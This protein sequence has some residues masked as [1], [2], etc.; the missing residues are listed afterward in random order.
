MAN[1]Q[2]YYKTT[3]IDSVTTQGGPQFDPAHPVNTSP[4]NTGLNALPP[5]RGAF[6]WYPYAPSPE[7][8]IVG[9]GGRTAEAGPVFY[10]DDFKNAARPFPPYYDGKLFIYEFMRHWIMAVTMDK[11]GDLASIEQFMPNAKFAAPIEMEFAPNGDLY[12][13]EYGTIWFSGN[14]DAR[15]VRIEYNGGNRAPIVAAALDH[16]KGALPL[17]ISLSSAGTLDLDEDSLQYAW[18]ITQRGKVVARSTA[19]NPGITFRQAGTYTATLTVTDAHGASTSSAPIEMV[20]GNQPPT[21]DIDLAGGNSTFF[22][23]GVPVRYAVRVS[24]REDG[25]LRSGRIPPRRV[26]VRAQYLPNGSEAA[27]PADQGRQLI[28][29]GDCL[30]CHQL[31]RKS[32]GPAYQG[33]ARKYRDDTTASARLSKKIREGGSGVWGP[34]AM[35][36]HPAL[37]AEQAD[38]MVAYI[39]SLADSGLAPLPPSLPVRGAYTPAAGSGD[40][41]HGVVLLRATYTD[42]GANG[43]PAITTEKTLELRSPTVI[44]ADGDMSNGVSKQTDERAP[45][46]IAVANRSGSSVALKQI[47]LT[48]V[49]AVTFLVA[50]P[51]QY[52]AKGGKIAVHLDAPTGALLGESEPILSTTDEAPL[53]RRVPLQRATGVHDLYFVF[54]NPDASGDALL[55]AVLTATFGP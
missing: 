49:G 25:T 50:A 53:P 47:D 2:T 7:F 45:V 39:R 28:E 40:A 33:V 36:A 4:N 44:V 13:L 35:P 43:V 29:A 10:R 1:N 54:T 6:I 48:G 37:S 41:P 22:F 51:A 26:A 14:D 30:S 15:L 23:P 16:P 17:R 38:A 46:P 27:S 8:P 24:D 9:T 31:N 55:F 21:V 20:A 3:V 34:V 12:V 5:A 18:T 19:P 42:R 32:I 11:N 52:Q